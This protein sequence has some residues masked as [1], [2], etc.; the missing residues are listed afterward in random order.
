MAGKCAACG[1]RSARS[2]K[3]RST[4]WKP[5]YRS[6]EYSNPEQATATPRARVRTRWAEALIRRWRYQRWKWTVVSLDIPQAQT[7]RL[8]TCRSH[9]RFIVPDRFVVTIGHMKKI[10]STNEA[11]GAIGPY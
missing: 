4:N 3:A 10:I 2:F 6:S 5:E 11:P 9:P 1:H 7:R 8:V